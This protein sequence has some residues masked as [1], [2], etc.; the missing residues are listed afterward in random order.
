MRRH[1]P[2]ILLTIAVVVGI[3]A[4]AGPASAR[5]VLDLCKV[6]PRSTIQD[7]VGTPLG[8]PHDLSTEPMAAGCHYPARAIGGTDVGLYAS[9]DVPLGIKRSFGGSFFATLDTFGRVYGAPEPVPG[10]GTTAYLAFTPGHLAQGA[11]LV[12][13]GPKRAVLIILVGEFVTPKNTVTRGRALAKL[14]LAT[15]QL[16]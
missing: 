9:N 12:L 13:S 2:V 5:T 3:A 4:F 8:N 10:I 15:R 7:R 11:L 6:V 1:D 16:A 14:I